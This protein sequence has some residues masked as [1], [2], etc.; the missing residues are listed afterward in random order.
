MDQ[1]VLKGKTI[2][3]AIQSRNAKEKG[4]QA[5]QKPNLFIKV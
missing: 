5:A 2:S 1:S 4:A 3:V